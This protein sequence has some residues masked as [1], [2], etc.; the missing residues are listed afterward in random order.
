MVGTVEQTYKTTSVEE[1]LDMTNEMKARGTL[2]MGLPNKDQ[3]KFHS[4]QDEK[5][6]MEAIEKRYGGNKESKK[7]INLKLLRSLPSK[8][9][10]HALIYRNKAKIETISLDDLYNNLK[11]NEPELTRSSRTSQ[12]PQNVAFIASN[13]TNSTYRTNEADNTAYGVSTAHTQGLQSVEER[14]VHYKKNKAVFADKINILNLKVR[15]KDNAIVEY[16]KNLEKTEKERDELK[17][18]L[19]TYQ[20]SSK[21]LNTL[22]KSQVSDKVKTGLGYKAAS[23]ATEDFVNSSTM[24]ENQENVKSRSDKGYHVVPP[25]YTGNYIPPKSDLMFIDEQVKSRNT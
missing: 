22:L 25:P 8:W 11:I 12:N 10:T 7:D 6:L 16:T 4:Y 9:K 18:T 21:S 15:L 14:L 1:K 3:L 2:L 23:P 20:N 5:F 24:I 13:S 17:L 19:E